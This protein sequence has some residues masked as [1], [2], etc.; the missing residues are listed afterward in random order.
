M[1]RSG[2]H[3]MG[4]LQTRNV[5]ED[6]DLDSPSGDVCE[7]CERP[8]QNRSFHHLIPRAVHSKTRFK[9]TF[10]RQEMR[11]RGLMLCMLCHSGIHDLVPDEKELARDYN[12]RD[13][14]LAHP[15]I[16]KHVAW[17]RKQK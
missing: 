13:S 9:K 7:L 2:P 11:E 16:A 14:L 4:Y 10:G 6:Q 5:E 12:T 17:V 1:K 3:F 8:G 15:A